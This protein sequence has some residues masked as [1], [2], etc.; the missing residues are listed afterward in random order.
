VVEVSEGNPLFVEEML[1][2]ALEE[3][4]PAGEL[5]VPATIQSLLATRLDG[6]EEDERAVIDVAA[7]QGKV[8]YEDALTALLPSRPP[9]D[10]TELLG[11]VLRKELI[12]PDR[13]RL[14]GRAY[15]FRHLLIRDAAYE[16]IPKEARSELHEGFARWLERAAGERATEYSEIVGYHLEQSY[17]YRAELG[18]LDDPARAIAAEAAER[19]GASG[20]RA[21]LR[22][23]GPAGINLIS[24]AASLLPPDDP[25]RVD[26]IPNVRAVQG[27]TDLSW[28]DKVLTEAVEAAATSGDRRLAAQALVQ[29]GLLRLFT[30]AGVTPEELIDISERATAV[31]AELDDDLGLARAWR[32]RAQ[33]HYLDRNLAQCAE[34][35]E[36]ALE[37]AR[38][39]RDRLEEQENAEWLMIALLLGP[40]RASDAARRCRLL[41]EQAADNRALQ[42]Q[43]LASLGAL[44][45]MQGDAAAA[46]EC[47]ERSRTLLEASGGTTWIVTFWQPF[48]YLWR[49]DPIA[50]ENEIRPG[51]EAL[52]RLGERS[53]FSSHSAVLSRSLYLQ[54]RNEEAEELTRECEA[55]SRP[56][57][58]HSQ[59][60]WRAVRAKLLARKGYFEEAEELALASLAIAED[61]DLD[62]AHADALMDFAEVLELSSRSGEAADAVREAI[63]L[64]EKKENN[65][66]TA[67]ARER[68]AQLE[69]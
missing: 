56:N 28:A 4:R 27:T 3:G 43:V 55:A 25:R 15:R 37:H 20:R 54:G 63:V 45:A 38:R 52:K 29:R 57:D 31:F 33:A 5:D 62:P 32:L 24:R 40:A 64:Y 9:A 26:L 11:L 53:H 13:P 21:F 12:R 14:G 19:L 7:V 69:G 18:S 61:S 60:M 39:A 2:L 42:A 6:L 41:F 10:I 59:I 49:N 51:Y 16:S 50:A 68:L 23:D 65:L 8:F 17:R 47:V 34:D 67:A 35:S 36:G 66:A 30:D 1:A 48:V 22:S 44:L 58:G 46:E